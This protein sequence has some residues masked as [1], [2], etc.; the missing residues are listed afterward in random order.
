MNHVAVLL[1]IPT[2][3]PIAYADDTND[4]IC[5]ESRMGMSPGQ[6]S[7]SIHGGQP[8]MPERRQRG[9]VINDL[10]NCPSP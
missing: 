6:I 5:Q 4:L 8:S 3:A 1:F 10:G 7:D 9:Q 2:S